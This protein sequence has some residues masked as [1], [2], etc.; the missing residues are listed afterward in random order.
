VRFD[1]NRL[2][3]RGLTAAATSATSPVQSNLVQLPQAH[4]T[5][6]HRPHPTPSHRLRMQQR[7]MYNVKRKWTSPHASQVAMGHRGSKARAWTNVDSEEAMEGAAEQKREK[8]LLARV[9]SAL[10]A[11]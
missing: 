4:P 8:E 6:S 9:H 7:E 1:F 3:A 2:S 11:R 5:P 10:A